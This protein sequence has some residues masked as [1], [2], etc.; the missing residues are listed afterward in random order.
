MSQ[1][2]VISHT[3]LFYSDDAVALLKYM[4]KWDYDERI[5]VQGILESRFIKFVLDAHPELFEVLDQNSARP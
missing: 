1:S 2:N 4:L 5:D 3:F